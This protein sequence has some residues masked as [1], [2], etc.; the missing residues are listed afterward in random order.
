ME[1]TDE[2]EETERLTLEPV[3]PPG[4]KT[5]DIRFTGSGS[6]YFR[7]W[8]VNL[9]LTLVTL[10]LYLPFA[11]A[12]R[13]AYFQNN[14]LVGGDPLGF[15]AD[16]WKMFRG[17]LLVLVLGVGYSAVSNFMPTLSW[18]ALLVFA[19]LWPALWRASLQFRL[20]NTSWRGV[21]LAFAGDMTS[22]YLAM[23][24][25]FIPALAFA[26]LM[27]DMSDA[28]SVSAEAAQQ[29]GI[30]AGVVI[31][32]FMVLLPWLWARIKAYQHGGYVFAQERTTFTA[33]A[34]RFY[35]LSIKITGVSLL[36]MMGLG[37]LMGVLFG[38]CLALGVVSLGDFSNLGEG[39]GLLFIVGGGVVLVMV[40]VLWPLIVG[41][42]MTSRFQ[43]LLWANTR[44]PRIR[45]TS[46]LKLAPLMRVNI[47]NWLLIALTL[48]LFWPFA[49]VRSARIRLE[50][51][52]VQVE[53]DVDQWVS[54]SLQQPAGVIGDAAGDFFGIDMGL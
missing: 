19:A 23:L 42:Y 28:E 6:E 31:L 53:G 17:Y 14:T 52:S 8:I 15:H 20:R 38:A 1:P 43:N 54:D 35:G 47:V 30:V 7:I 16:P 34:K 18:V 4:P 24:P 51:M 48:G 21:R 49:K 27:P 39:A 13:M 12:R 5:L 3:A 32:G 9:L 2:F 11:R 37:T 45:F 10:T 25:F 22:A 44:S 41:S 36:V 33:G 46:Q 50:A 26:L 40:Y 29:A